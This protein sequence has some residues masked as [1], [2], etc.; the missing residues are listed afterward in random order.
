MKRRQIYG[1]I[2]MVSAIAG[3]IT[4]FLQL[5]VPAFVLWGIAILILFRMKKKKS[6]K[7]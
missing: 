5:Y 4:W 7:K 2:G 1:I 6:R 3:G